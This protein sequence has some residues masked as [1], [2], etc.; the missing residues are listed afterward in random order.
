MTV[1][2]TH[3]HVPFRETHIVWEPT[4]RNGAKPAALKALNTLRVG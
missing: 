4:V 3:L 2:D 1:R